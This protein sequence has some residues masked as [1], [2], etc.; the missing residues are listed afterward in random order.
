[1]KPLRL[2]T[3]WSKCNCA[4][5]RA[6]GSAELLHNIVRAKDEATGRAAY[7]ARPV[8]CGLP[9]EEDAEAIECPAP[10]HCRWHDPA[11]ARYQIVCVKKRG[12][13]ARVIAR[14]L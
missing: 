3:I 4:E 2:V 12:H 5:L 9:S 1:M 14:A 11:G 7:L 8:H 6:L 10:P 13:I